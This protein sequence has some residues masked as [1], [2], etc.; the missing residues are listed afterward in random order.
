M[1]WYHQPEVATIL[2]IQK[3]RPMSSILRMEIKARVQRTGEE[4]S[5]FWT[6]A[7]TVITSRS[8]GNKAP[9]QFETFWE[10]DGWEGREVLLYHSLEAG[11]AY[12]KPCE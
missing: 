9:E 12:M 7:P 6:K 10:K 1:L 11:Y 3:E 2:A 8:Y 5:F 4:V